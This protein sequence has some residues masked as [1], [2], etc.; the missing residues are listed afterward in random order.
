[1]EAFLPQKCWRPMFGNRK[2]DVTE[3]NIQSPPPARLLLMAV[4]N[5]LGGH[6]G[7]DGPQVGDGGRLRHALRATWAGGYNV[8]KDVYKTTVFELCRWRNAHLPEGR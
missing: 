7:D 5:Q 3:E 1:M 2:E 6:G 4:S 8:L